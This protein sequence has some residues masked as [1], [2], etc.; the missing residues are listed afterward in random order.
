MTLPSDQ[1]VIIPAIT[2]AGTISIAAS[3]RVATGD[4]TTLAA[5]TSGKR[6]I[7]PGIQRV[8]IAAD[9]PVNVGG[10]VCTFELFSAWSS[11]PYSG[12]AWALASAPGDD[13]LALIVQQDDAGPTAGR[14]AHNSDADGYCYLDTTTATMWER[15]GPTGTWTNKGTTAVLWVSSTTGSDTDDDNPVRATVQAA[16]DILAASSDLTGWNVIIALKAGTYAPFVLK[17]IAGAP[18]LLKICGEASL[19]GTPASLSSYIIS[20]A[21]PIAAVQATNLKDAW[22]LEGFTLTSTKGHLLQ[23]KGA[24]LRFNQLRFGA[25]A[26]AHMAALAAG[27]IV[28]AGNGYEIAGGGSAHLLA[29]GSGG[30]VDLQAEATVAAPTITISAASTFKTAFAWARASGHIFTGTGLI[31]AGAIAKT[32]VVGKRWRA[33]QNSSIDSGQSGERYLAGNAAGVAVK[34]GEYI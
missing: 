19:T 18:T 8:I 31:F 1:A 21:S 13:E 34:N 32:A 16:I 28:M 33:E 14:A 26:G 27:S 12:K 15:N 3:A 20:S 22:T 24:R 25:A 30:T 17:E 7:L 11:T 29:N 6:F 5:I 23:A 10:G 9:N 2:D 4:A